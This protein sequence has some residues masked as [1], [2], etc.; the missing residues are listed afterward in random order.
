MINLLCWPNP[1]VT[2]SRTM[3]DA[4]IDRARSQEATMFY[5][6]TDADILLFLDDDIRYK[7]DEIIHMC[8]EAYRLKTIVG[9]AYVVKKEDITWITPKPLNSD[10]IYFGD[11][12]NSGTVEVRWVAGGAMAIHRNVLTDM[13]HELPLPLCHPKDMKFWPFFL[14]QLWQHPSG[15]YLYLSE[16]Y[17]FCENARKLGYKIYMDTT[18][19]LGHAGRYVYE[20]ADLARPPREFGIAIKYTD[21]SNA[22]ETTKEIG[23]KVE[24]KI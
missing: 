17:S 2:F 3:G 8:R 24:V 22:P 5:R 12:V 23:E 9:A 4:M 21:P 15:D 7:P 19:S 6:D 14:P 13:I 11:K 10:P 18:V 1:K 20:L 16:D